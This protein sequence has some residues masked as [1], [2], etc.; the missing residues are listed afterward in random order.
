M[1]SK[2]TKC[3]NM[4]CQND[5]R[6]HC[7]RCKVVSYCSHQCQKVDWKTHK[8]S[9]TEIKEAESSDAPSDGAK[10]CGNE[11]CCKIGL[12]RCS[13]CKSVWYC[14]EECQKFAWK[15]HKSTCDPKIG[16]GEAK[17]QPKMANTPCGRVNCPNEGNKKCTRCKNVSYC[18]KGCQ[19]ED[20]SI[21]K[22]HCKTEAKQSAPSSLPGEKPGSKNMS[23]ASFD[24][25]MRSNPT[26]LNFMLVL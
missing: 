20:W 5:G 26:A 7:S 17:C 24:E 2:N 16:S 18:S 15:Q 4:G 8:L 9:C 25:W 11:V 23:D 19:K 6:F 3:I 10:T 12:K 13:Q 22:A 14:S 1:A 21:H